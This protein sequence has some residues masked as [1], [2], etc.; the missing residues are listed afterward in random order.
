MDTVTHYQEII[1]RVLLSY[2]ETPYAHGNIQCKPVFDTT[3]NSFMLITEGWDGVRRIH[4]CLVHIEIINEKIWVQRDDTDR[5]ITYDLVE[6]GIPKDQ[7]VLG[8]QE[9]GV[10]QFTGYA[11]A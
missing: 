10:R 1:Q 2:T 3:R 11:V 5:G 7:I 4:G 6:S 9:P 8:F